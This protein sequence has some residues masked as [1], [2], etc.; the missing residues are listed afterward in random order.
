MQK[1]MFAGV[2]NNFFSYLIV[3]HDFLVILWWPAFNI[4]WLL[5]EFLHLYF[6]GWLKFLIDSN[7]LVWQ[8]RWLLRQLDKLIHNF[9]KMFALGALNSAQNIKILI[10]N[11]LFINLFQNLIFRLFIVWILTRFYFFFYVFA[12]SLVK[13]TKSFCLLN[14]TFLNLLLEFF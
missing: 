6:I 1:Y 8:V 2:T 4:N 12:D 10:N 13:I 14:R 3:A 9:Y 5:K 7:D 11:S